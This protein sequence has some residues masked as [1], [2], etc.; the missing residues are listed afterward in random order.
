MRFPVR[1][2]PLAALVL[3]AGCVAP[4]PPAPQRVAAPDPF[5]TA[6]ERGAMVALNA[7]ARCHQVRPD[8]PSGQEAAAPSF[9]EIANLA[10]RSQDYLRRFA[11][12][13]HVVRTV[14]EPQPTMP[15][16]FLSPEDRE[17][18][19]AFIRSYRRS[20]A[21]DGEAPEPLEAFE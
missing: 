9:M 1:L 15:A 13:R 18:V 11:T 12:T 10:G 3:I 7:C 19:I 16:L 14:G 6:A 5:A 8:R 2:S 17:D 20:D 21:P 4:P